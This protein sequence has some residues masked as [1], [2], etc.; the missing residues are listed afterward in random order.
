ME[1]QS[2]QRSSGINHKSRV[3]YP[4]PRFLSSAAWPLMAKKH[5][6]GLINQS[7]KPNQSFHKISSANLRSSTSQKD[8]TFKITFK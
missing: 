7:I 4:S 2:Y 6:N 5:S 3:L 1:N 8:Y